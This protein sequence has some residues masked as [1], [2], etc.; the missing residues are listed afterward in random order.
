MQFIP[1]EHHKSARF[2]DVALKKSV[3]VVE[4]AQQCA[5]L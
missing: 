5:V 2:A 4:K 1:F 3:R